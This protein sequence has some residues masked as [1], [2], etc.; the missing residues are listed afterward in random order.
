MVEELKIEGFWWLP[1]RQDLELPGTLTFS[2]HE[3][4]SLEVQGLISELPELDIILGCSH[5]GEDITLYKCFMSFYEFNI[6]GFD[7]LTFSAHFGFIGAHFSR[8]SEIKFKKISVRYRYLDEWLGVSVFD[9]THKHD[10]CLIEVNDKL[11]ESIEINLL[12]DI[13]IQFQIKLLT[14]YPSQKEVCIKKE[15]LFT[16]EFPEEKDFEDLYRYI[17]IFQNLLSLLISET[18]YPIKIYGYSEKL[19]YIFGDKKYYKPIEII[20]KLPPFM[21]KKEEKTIYPFEMLCPYLSIKENITTIFN[22][23]LEKAEVLEPVHDL[24]FGVI[25]NGDLY[26]RFQFLSL[27]MALEVYHRRMIRNEDISR[28]KHEKRIRR[29]LDNIPNEQDRKWLQEKLKYSNEPSLRKR[30]R[31]IYKKLKGIEFIKS[32]IPNEKKFIDKVVNTRNYLVHYDLSL[33]DKA[34]RGEK[35]YWLT[36]KLRVMVEMCLL[37]ELGLSDETINNIYEQNIK[38]S[39]LKNNPV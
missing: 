15:A 38:Y 2:P 22:N 26:L 37:K 39:S 35:L 17:N 7:R 28:E 6:F 31:D 9:S 13:K 12:E 24:Y 16:L 32:I 14:I 34:L 30:L 3:G 33:K 19:A 18:T 25:Y 36:Q 10:E 20:Y 5:Q 27:V 11:Q 4:F 21:L 29:I 23:W 1:E 8:S